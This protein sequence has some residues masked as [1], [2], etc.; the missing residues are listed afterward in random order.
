MVHVTWGREVSSGLDGDK[1]LNN[2]FKLGVNTDSWSWVI[3]FITQCSGPG[4]S[5]CSIVAADRCE[6]EVY[7]YKVSLAILCPIINLNFC[8]DRN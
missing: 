5:L 3:D 6:H 1:V 8:L 4:S 2:F 7:G